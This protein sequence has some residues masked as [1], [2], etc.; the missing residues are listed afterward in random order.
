MGE[1]GSRQG[2]CD[3]ESAKTLPEAKPAPARRPR[4]AARSSAVCLSTKEAAFARAKATLLPLRRRF[5]SPGSSGRPIP[6]LD[7]RHAVGARQYAS[8]AEASLA[9]ASLAVRPA[10]PR[11][12]RTG[13]RR[14]P[15]RPLPAHSCGFDGS[16]YALVSSS[17]PD[18]PCGR[19][20][21]RGGAGGR[22]NGR[23]GRVGGRGR[24]GTGARRRP[25]AGRH[26]SASH[27]GHRGSATA[28]Q[29]SAPQR[30]ASQRSASKPRK[31]SAGVG[32]PHPPRPRAG[33][34]VGAPR[35]GRS[36]RRPNLRSHG[37]ARRRARQQPAAEPRLRRPPAGGRGRQRGRAGGLPVHGPASQ[38]PHGCP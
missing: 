24:A 38:R 11:P 12:V 14:L 16:S 13:S 35:L 18:D 29:R 36:L 9:E 37:G 7:V 1:G 17:A 20:S 33:A 4:T 10:S 19:S 3:R 6:P 5:S 32:A 26:Q 21:S 15:G 2:I 31:A 28:P 25:T 27:V 34:P 22:A 8:L 23:S 30:S